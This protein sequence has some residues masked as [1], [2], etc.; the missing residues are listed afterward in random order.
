MSFESNQLKN[1]LPLN[2]CLFVIQSEIFN[3]DSLARVLPRLA[4]AKCIYF[5]TQG[6]STPIPAYTDR[7]R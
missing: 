5:K 1:P 4:S 3:R 2:S 6:K 7:L